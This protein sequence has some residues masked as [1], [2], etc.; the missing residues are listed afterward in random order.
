MR[1]VRLSAHVDYEALVLLLEYVYLGCLQVG[2]ETVKK[3]K[4]LA[5]RCNLQPLLQLLY[6]QCPKWGTPFPS[7][8]LTSTLD[9]T[10]SCFSYGLLLDQLFIDILRLHVFGVILCFLFLLSI[11]VFISLQNLSVNSHILE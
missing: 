10:G 7:S 5:K 11:S 8:D 3:L 6:R 4:I 2:E 9:S 1:E